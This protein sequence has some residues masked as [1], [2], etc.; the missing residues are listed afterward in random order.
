MTRRDIAVA[1]EKFDELEKMI[2]FKELPK[3][4]QGLIQ[5]S[6]RPANKVLKEILEFVDSRDLI[7][8]A[9]ISLDR[10]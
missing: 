5:D 10:E 4:E 1:L 3:V 9:Q 7:E 2:F 6:I 8:I